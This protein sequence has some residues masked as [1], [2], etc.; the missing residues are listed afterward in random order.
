VHLAGG[1]AEPQVAGAVDGE[2]AVA[3]RPGDDIGEQ[4]LRQAAAVDPQARAG[5]GRP[6]RGSRR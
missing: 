4:A 5:G 2:R 3:E 1:A 6:A